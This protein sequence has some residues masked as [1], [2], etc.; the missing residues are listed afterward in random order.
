MTSGHALGNIGRFDAAGVVLAS[1]LIE[2]ISQRLSVA[3]FK[4]N[5]GKMSHVL[6]SVVAVM[7]FSPE[8]F[9]KTVTGLFKSEA[10]RQQRG[11]FITRFMYQGNDAAA[12][13]LTCHC[14]GD[15]VNTV[16][17][18]CIRTTHCCCFVFWLFCLPLMAAASVASSLHVIMCAGDV[19]L[20]NA[21]LFSLCY[22]IGNMF[23]AP[24]WPEFYLFQWVIRSITAGHCMGFNDWTKWYGGV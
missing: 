15:G 3:N 16:R 1:W 5:K 20:N 23:C 24:A 7:L 11:Q 12:P 14:S 17:R 8:A 22:V 4:L 2:S 9:G 6:V 13:L 18:R 10:A 19:C 21:A